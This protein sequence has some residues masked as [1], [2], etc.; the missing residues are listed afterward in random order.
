MTSPAEKRTDESIDKTRSG[1]TGFPRRPL[2]KALGA[3]AALTAASGI[4]TAGGDGSDRQD[5]SGSDGQGG[6]ERADSRQIDPTFGYPATDAAT[7]PEGLEPDH[8]VELL[9]APPG[10]DQPPF[11]YFEPTGL[12]VD[13][14]DVVQFTF[15][16]PDHTVTAFHPDIGL[17][18]RV[19]Q[20]VEP[21]SSPVMGPGAV[22]LYRFEHEGVYDL[23]CAP[24]LDFGMVMRVVVGDLAEADLPEYARTV[25]TLPSKED[26][27]EGLNQMSDQNEGCEWPYL[28]PAEI[29]GVDVLDPMSVQEMEE[30]PFEEV[31]AEH[32]YEL[33]EED[34]EQE[35]PTGSTVQVGTHPEYGEILVG[36][37]GLTLYMFDQDTQGERGSACHDD[38]V[39]AWPPLIA[40]EEPVAG[41]GVTAALET[42]ERESGE[43]QV[44]ANGWP[45]YYFTQDEAP[46]DVNGQGVNDVWWI[47]EPDGTPIRA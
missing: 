15:L 28:M 21:F 4:T 12:S 25:E 36:P 40:D 31:I 14:G 33:R 44:M 23:Y 29:L 41:D 19:P 3:G 1:G 27:S 30:V 10:P 2:L 39:E 17:P 5:D 22:W 13:P 20:E 8:E 16:S 32:G 42:F 38:C 7:I 24:H 34:P 11:L 45:L 18:P 37:D 26:A 6:D 43:M 35:E 47:L 46:G 9:N